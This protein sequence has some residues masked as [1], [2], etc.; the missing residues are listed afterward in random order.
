[1]VAVLGVMVVGLLITSL[2]LSSTVSALGTTTSTRA[3]VQSQAAAE[4][5]IAVA[6][7]ALKGAASACT[8]PMTSS[9]AP[10][11]TVSVSRTSSSSAG[12]GAVWVPGCPLSGTTF[13]KITSKGFASA[14]GVGGNTRGDDSV[15]EAIYANNSVPAGIPASGS[16]IYTFNAGT[17][18]TAKILSDGTRTASLS[19]RNGDVS[20]TETS[21]IQGDV[22]AQ[23]GSVAI[24]G[25]C[26]V[27][28]SVAAGGEVSIFG[29][30]GANVSSASTQTSTITPDARIGGGVTLAGPLNAWSPRCSSPSTWDNAGNACA[31]KQ[32][33]G[34]TS[35]TTNMTGSSRPVAPVVP[36][37]V[38]FNFVAS[39]WTS[40]GYTVV[41][42]PDNR[43]YCNIDNRTKSL[44][45]VTAIP[46]YTTPTVIDARACNSL[47][48]SNSAALTLQ[49]GADVAFVAKA[50]NI[51]NFTAKST[52]SAP[53]ELRFIVPDTTA[54][55]TN[56]CS[57]GD[58]DINSGVRI[59]SSV[60]ALIY[61]PCEISNSTVNWRG[62]FFAGK[63][64]FNS[65]SGLTYAPLGL[66]GVDLGGAATGGTAPG[67]PSLGDLQSIRDVN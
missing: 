32:S 48:F 31:A 41:T 66:P 45:H 54:N 12:S 49:L 1:M 39:D 3:G 60:S 33:S 38:D 7:V 34:A 22:R 64:S 16:A 8:T 67:T 58:V 9:T 24:G 20:C 37:W 47:T 59:E 23:F 42:W 30:I 25:N 35:V 19:V 55:G 27:A 50:F 65:N 40:R 2:I 17:L 6:T 53:R 26:A 61:T 46:G 18:N 57:G 11:Y 15:V 13:I 52:T 21:E 28:G 5:G 51:E 29:R 4:A 10:A 56:T 36:G 44:S 63:V 43:D 14:K 62:Q